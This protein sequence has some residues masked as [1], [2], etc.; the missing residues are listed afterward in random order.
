[1]DNG[2]SRYLIL[3][4]DDS[5]VNIKVV[6]GFLKNE[7]YQLAFAQSGKVAINQVKTQKIDLILLDIM[8]PEMDGLEVCRILKSSPSTMEV[9]VVFLTGKTETESIIAGFESGGVDYLTKPFNQKELLARVKTHLSLKQ[10]QEDLQNSYR[11]LSK[12]TQ[13]CQLFVPERFLSQ[14][15]SKDQSKQFEPQRFQEEKFSVLFTDV[16]SYTR[17]AEK[18]K[19]QQIFEFLNNLFGIME[20]IITSNK[21]FVDKFI[22]DAIMA[23]FDQASSAEDAV[24]TAIA[25]QKELDR[26]NQG[27]KN[28]SL[29][30]I[31]IGINTGEVMVG[32]LGATG[33]LNPTVIG[34]NVNL[35]AR[36]ESLTK[37]YNAKILISQWTRTEISEENYLLREID[38]VIVK[39]KTEPVI[40]YEVCDTD[41]P[42]IR[43]K[44]MATREHLFRGIVSYKIL[45]FDTA[46]EFFNH[47]LDLFPED[48]VT[49]K[50]IQ[51]CRYFQKSP[52][53]VEG[54]FWDG[55][56]N[57]KELMIEQTL[58]YRIPRF[59]V[60][61]RVVI[62]TEEK[63]YVS[64]QIDISTGGAKVQINGHLEI[65]S[66]VRSKIFLGNDSVCSELAED[67]IVLLARV[68]W[69]EGSGKSS[70]WNIGL[71]FLNISLKQE[72]QLQAV[73]KI[74]SS[75]N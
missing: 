38:T 71:E 63:E 43:E 74:I 40:I 1:M 6:A 8:M 58:E 53:I 28:K 22:G 18:M 56:L 39:G 46:W 35:A 66:I 19:L 34:D 62:E 50:Y 14:I 67:G 30:E 4:V 69:C 41:P 10:S 60:D 61:F 54:Y 37:H 25:M 42:G 70:I 59:F 36:M 3:I 48:I 68:A 11:E 26:Y 49:Q 75:K 17:R 72:E 2:N 21:G 52:P 13:A 55:T 73:I 15:L 7:G 23:C 12:I 47:C 44:K 31:G 45:D 29:I 20:P 57:K 24:Q 32:T 33:R 65:G 51:R 16:R 64:N 27:R 5:P 9:P